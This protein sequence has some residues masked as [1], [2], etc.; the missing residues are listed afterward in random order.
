[1]AAR[2][3]L[4]IVDAIRDLK[5]AEPFE[6]F[7]IVMSSGDKYIIESGEN[8]VEM[9]TQ[10]FYGS[11]R[12]DWFVFIRMTHIAGIEQFAEKKRTR[13]RKAS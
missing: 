9:A 2:K 11:P 5:R 12:S 3:E 10:F 8:L 13:G 1:M 4:T 6:P 7:R